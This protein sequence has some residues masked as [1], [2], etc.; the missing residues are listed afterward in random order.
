MNVYNTSYNSIVSY[1]L[2]MHTSI[3]H[4]AYAHTHS[5]W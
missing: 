1:N 3:H 2:Q 4:S 5:C